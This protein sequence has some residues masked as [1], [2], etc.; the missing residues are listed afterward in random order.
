MKLVGGCLCGKVR[1]EAD[2]PDLLIGHCQCVICRRA[3]TAAFISTIGI[4]RGDFRWTA[5]EQHVTSYKS[6]IGKLRH[7]CSLCGSY[8]G[9]ERSTPAR[10]VVRL[11]A[12]DDDQTIKPTIALNH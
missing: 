2:R 6:S 4:L 12:L 10:F 11:T 8:L 9:D 5:G 3:N 1:F 7:F